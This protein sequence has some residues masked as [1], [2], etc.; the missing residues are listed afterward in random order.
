MEQYHLYCAWDIC[1]EF[2]LTKKKE[3]KSNNEKISKDK[4]EKYFIKKS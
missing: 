1:L 3:K 4:K 2:E